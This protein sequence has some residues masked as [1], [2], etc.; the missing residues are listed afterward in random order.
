MP[1]KGRKGR[2]GRS[3]PPSPRPAPPTAAAKGRASTLAVASNTSHFAT[4]IPFDEEWLQRWPQEVV[5]ASIDQSCWLSSLLHSVLR[6]RPLVTYLLQSG[7]AYTLRKKSLVRRFEAYAPALC[8]KATENLGRLGRGGRATR[9]DHKA[10]PSSLLWE[11]VLVTSAMWTVGE[12][13]RASKQRAAERSGVLLDK[14][15]C[16]NLKITPSTF[17]YTLM[18][19]CPNFGVGNQEDIAEATTFFLDTLNREMLADKLSDNG[20]TDM[21]LEQA[22]DDHTET[23]VSKLF[24]G[25]QRTVVTCSCGNVSTRDEPQWIMALPIPGPGNAEA[26]AAGGGK[27]K[28]T[29]KPRAAIAQKKGRGK[30]G[31]DMTDESASVSVDDCMRAHFAE[32]SLQG[33]NQYE[34][35][36]CGR[37]RDASKAISLSE[38]PEVAILQ[39]KHFLNNSVKVETHV[40]LPLELNLDAYAANNGSAAASSS[41]GER[42]I[43][44]LTALVVHTGSSAVEG[45]YIMY[46]LVPDAPT[47]PQQP[48]WC[49][50]D[51]AK[52][53]AEFTD[54]F[55]L[56]QQAYMAYYPRDSVPSM[57]LPP[58]PPP[59]PGHNTPS[60][61]QLEDSE[62]TSGTLGQGGGPRRSPCKRQVSQRSPSPPPIKSSVSSKRRRK[63]AAGGGGEGEERGAV[64]VDVDGDVVMAPRKAA[65]ETAA[66]SRGDSPARQ[67]R[68]Q[69]AHD[70][71]RTPAAGKKRRGV[72]SEDAAGGGA[73]EGAGVASRRVQP[74]RAAKAAASSGAGSGEG[75][76]WASREE[77]KKAAGG[78][79]STDS[80][81]D[82]G[83]KRQSKKPPAAAKAKQGGKPKAKPKAKQGNKSKGSGKG[84]GKAKGRATKPKQVAKTTGDGPAARVGLRRRE[85]A[86]RSGRATR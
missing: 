31:N 65:G 19:T 7:S 13:E 34:C 66:A 62:G 68:R 70:E 42:G 27:G 79:R 73:S 83:N 16:Q 32:E 5:F 50:Y 15:D 64:D 46:T 4:P 14:G 39:F 35:E 36:P 2:K 80:G 38:V 23:P 3:L 85:Q 81:F 57:V 47:G 63:D 86:K 56:S 67:L 17:F 24:R 71:R 25:V 54:E 33:D 69:L 49:L 55:V 48:R 9:A 1:T 77:R 6:V 75:E 53:V 51:D 58:R 44:K 37:K 18:R 59:P 11:T 45:H 74:K 26:A 20:A 29:T 84:K 52:P 61:S 30:R 12:K 8:D 40:E 82:D 60:P 21:T 28:Q 41:A 10:P 76:G 72:G 78:D 43:H 22:G